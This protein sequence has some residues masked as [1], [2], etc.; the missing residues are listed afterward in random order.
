ML[1]LDGKINIDLINKSNPNI[2][3]YK[4]LR[5]EARRLVIKMYSGNPKECFTFKLN[6][7]VKGHPEFKLFSRSPRTQKNPYKNIRI[8][9][10]YGG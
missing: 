1:L 5:K 7:S 3:G 2:F 8:S 4:E 9:P 10:Y 6:S